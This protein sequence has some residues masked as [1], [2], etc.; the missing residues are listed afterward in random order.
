MDMK[1]DK[2]KEKRKSSS[3]T[4]IDFTF[5]HATLPC[6]M[7]SK[8][9]IF[10]SIFRGFPYLPHFTSLH[11]VP[12]ISL[13]MLTTNSSQWNRALE[14]HTKPLQL[15]NAWSKMH[16]LLWMTSFFDLSPDCL[17]TSQSK[18]WFPFNFHFWSF[19]NSYWRLIF[20]AAIEFLNFWSGVRKGDGTPPPHPWFKTWEGHGWRIAD[21]HDPHRP[22]CY[23]PTQEHGGWAPDL[24]I[25]QN[26]GVNTDIDANL[27]MQRNGPWTQLGVGCQHCVGLC[28]NAGNANAVL[29][30]VTLYTTVPQSTQGLQTPNYR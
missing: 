22:A 19:S 7:Y 25:T 6:A 28:L 9:L 3:K 4:N 20:I 30:S 5:T 24:N 15:Q 18:R 27:L 26:A 8:Q 13:P 14:S 29:T 16:Q 17:H 11:W 1:T 23:H 21:L 10:Y 12:S 2:W